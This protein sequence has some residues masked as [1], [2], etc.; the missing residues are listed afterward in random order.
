MEYGKYFTSSFF[1]DKQWYQWHHLMQYL[2]YNKHVSEFQLYFTYLTTFLIAM[3]DRNNHRNA[4]ISS[5]SI[6]RYNM[7]FT[8]ERLGYTFTQKIHC[9]DH[10][11]V[12]WQRMFIRIFISLTACYI[13]QRLAKPLWPKYERPKCC[14]RCCKTRI[15]SL[16]YALQLH[17]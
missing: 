11:K 12:M 3:G 15:L 6:T 9:V 16:F 1:K 5:Q 8:F 4:Y 13:S 14:N 2:A 10:E 17:T 7:R